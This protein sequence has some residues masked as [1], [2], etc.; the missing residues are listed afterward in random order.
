MPTSKFYFIVLLL[1]PIS[2]WA[3]INKQPSIGMWRQHV[4]FT[5]ALDLVQTPNHVFVASPYGVFS[6]NQATDEINTYTKVNGLSETAARTLT[7]NASL[8]KIIIAYNNSNIDVLMPNGNVINIDD[9]KRNNI[10]ADKTINKLYN[11]NNLLLVSTGFGIVAIDLVRNET[12]DTW[13]LGPAGAYEKVNNI[14][15]L[16]NNYYAATANG[17][18]NISTNAPALANG[19]NWQRLAGFENG[20]IQNIINFSNQL[21]IQ[22][23]DSLFTFNGTTSNF[24]FTNNFN[25]ENINASGNQLTICQTSS[26]GSSK[27]VVLNANGSIAYEVARPGNISVPLQATIASGKLYVADFF[28]FINTFNNT[29]FIKKY[30]I[31]APISTALGQIIFANDNMYFSCGGVNNLWQYTFNSSGYYN[32]KNNEWANINRGNTPILD[33]VF[34]IHVL[35]NNN[36]TN[37]FYAG[38]YGGGLLE[39]NNATNTKRIIKQNGL[40]GAVG[41]IGSFR[42]GGLAVDA[43]GNTW[44]ANYGAVQSMVCLQPNGNFLRFGHPYSFFDNAFGKIVIDQNNQKWITA[45][46]GGGLVCYNSGANLNSAA[47][48]NWKL[49]RAGSTQGNLTDNEI[50]CIAIDKQNNLWVGAINGVNIIPC[51]DQVFTANCQAIQP[52]IKSGNFAGFLLQNQNIQTIAVDGANRKW[53]GTQNGV[54]LVSADGDKVI[55][56]FTETNSPLPSN[57]V[58]SIG[59]NDATGEVFMGTSQGLVSYMGNATEG[60]ETFNNVLVYPNPVSKGYT[61]TIAIKGLAAN[62]IVKIISTNGVLVHQGIANGGTYSFN[63]RNYNGQPIATGVYTVIMRSNDGVEKA[64]AKI[65]FIQ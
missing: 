39:V 59:I 58:K 61:G 1:M 25:I 13:V 53:I 4:P 19:N 56:N 41:D 65:A 23:N 64:V 16:N 7:Y 51:V 37:K 22:R 52:I 32:L 2:I 15:V 55:E 28:G 62:A 6:I 43:E 45:P 20:N 36:T 12:K 38:S 63:G 30:N 49:Y 8:Q 57:D 24:L 11:F 21:V 5:Q 44:I 3:Q 60:N 27:V 42:I 26:A 48:D 17:I 35:A 34:D 31:N 47:D 33:T 18:R 10:A 14:A 9:I 50:N 29:N 40:S 54:F 46:K